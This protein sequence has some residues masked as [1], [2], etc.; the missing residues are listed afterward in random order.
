MYWNQLNIK[1]NQLKSIES[2]LNLIENQLKLIESKLKSIENQLKSVECKLK[3]NWNVSKSNDSILFR[4]RH[5]KKLFRGGHTNQAPTLL[6][7]PTQWVYYQRSIVFPIKLYPIKYIQEPWLSFV[8]S[9]YVA[10]RIHRAWKGYMP[11]LH[12]FQGYA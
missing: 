2:K 4:P 3:V 8:L 9:H 7:F 10:N 5:S 11:Q 12:E 6:Y 1:W